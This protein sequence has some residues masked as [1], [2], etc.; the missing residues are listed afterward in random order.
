[1][2]LEELH[3]EDQREFLE[4]FYKD[5]EIQAL[6]EKANQYQ[7]AGMYIQAMQTRRKIEEVKQSVF[8]GYIAKLEK[9]YETIDLDTLN[10]PTEIKHNINVL[11]TTLFMACDI[12]NSAVVDF[13]DELHKF[14]PT[15]EMETFNDIMAVAKQARGKLEYLNKYT[16]LNMDFIF[17]EK[18]DDMFDMMKNKAKVILRKKNSPEWGKNMQE[19]ME[20]HK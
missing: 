10:L 2:K 16:K 15:L 19:F 12:I 14:D 7:R 11:F 3:P 13:N 8:N 18:C 20:K 4:A 5:S 1:M 9:H 17:A 6:N